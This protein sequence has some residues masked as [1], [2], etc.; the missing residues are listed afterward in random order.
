MANPIDHYISGPNFE[1]QLSPVD[2]VTPPIYSR[3]ILIFSNPQQ[4]QDQGVKALKHGLQGAVNEYPVLAGRLGL[5]ASG[6]S[7]TKGHARLRVR[8]LDL[9]FA[10]LEE[11]NFAESN[12]PADLVSDLPTFAT[13]REEWHVCRLQ[14]NFVTHGLLLV[15]SVH[16]TIMDGYGIAKVIQSLARYSRLDGLPNIETTP[17]RWDRA[18]M[19]V[20]EQNGDIKS[21]RAY[22]F[23]SERPNIGPTSQPVVTTTFKISKERLEKLKT[24]AS[25]CEGWITT[26]DAVNALCWRTQAKARHRAGLISATD[27]ARFAFPVEFRKLVEPPLSPEFTGNAVLMTKTGIKVKDLLGNSG[28]A[29][30]AQSI[31]EGVKDV[32]QEYVKNFISVANSQVKPGQMVINLKLEDRHTAFGS[33]S[34]KSFYHGDWDPLIGKYRTMRLASGVT[35]EGM[36]IILPALEDGSWEVT[37][38]LEEDQLGYFMEDEEWRL[39]TA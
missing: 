10:Q 29:Y 6:W 21:L 20:T 33:T 3:R 30:A 15:V 19:P 14:A 23:V 26:H 1:C 32:D 27:L 18:F 8:E 36:S 34:Y 25:P 2:Q 12:F 35:G 7:V 37:V 11:S 5:T 4:D 9:D 39:Y 28:L 24:D 13:P 17:V 22:S 38:T 31:R 16:H